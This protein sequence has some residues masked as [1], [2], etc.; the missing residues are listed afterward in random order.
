MDI[1]VTTELAQINSYSLQV[2]DL[3][4]DNRNGGRNKVRPHS[5]P[6]VLKLREGAEKSALFNSKELSTSPLHA[7][8]LSV[9]PVSLLHKLKSKGPF[10][11]ID[12]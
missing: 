3:N 7:C 4:G 9:C 10:T 2:E 5:I 11:T 12:G 8:V 6:R 1:Q